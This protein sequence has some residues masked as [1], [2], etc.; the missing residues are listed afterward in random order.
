MNRLLWI[1]KNS[2]YVPCRIALYDQSYKEF[3]CHLLKIF[4]AFI[5]LHASQLRSKLQWN[6]SQKSYIFIHE[7]TFK[8]VGC[9]IAAILYRPQCVNSSPPSATSCVPSIGSDNGLSPIWCQAITWTIAGLLLIGHLETNFSEIQIKIQNLSFM[10]MHLKLSKWLPFCLGG[11]GD[12]LNFWAYHL[13]VTNHFLNQC[14][15]IIYLD[16]WKPI[17]VKFEWQYCNF[18]IWKLIYGFNLNVLNRMVPEFSIDSFSNIS[19]CHKKSWTQQS[20]KQDCIFS[21]IEKKNLDPKP[22]DLYDV[23]ELTWLFWYSFWLGWGGHAASQW[24]ARF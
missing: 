13:F 15:Y 19:S 5:D 3:K 14:W 8:N 23:M 18:H 12:E 21:Y 9:E 2:Q 17:T 24:E 22:V 16:P 6:F 10:N 20:C 1:D 11:V 4:V 7:N